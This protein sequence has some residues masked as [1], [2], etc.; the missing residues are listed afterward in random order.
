MNNN[1]SENMISTPESK[2][3]SS[4]DIIRF[5]SRLDAK[6]IPMHS[7]IIYSKD[8][9]VS[10]RYYIPSG[11]GKL[12]RM[13][14]ISKS[15][16]SLAVSLLIDEGKLSLSDKIISYFPEKIKGEVHP[17]LAEMT[18]EN[19]LMMRTCY[20][21]T[22]YNKF[23]M[24]SDWVG[25]FFTAI[26]THKPGTVFHYDTSSAHVLAALVEKITGKKLWD[27]F[28]EKLFPLNL[29]HES[30]FL[31]DG[32]GV[33]MGGSGLMATTE[34]LLKIGILL[35]NNGI[36]NGSQLISQEYILKATSCLSPNLVACPVPSEGS[37]YGYMFWCNERGGYSCYGMGGQ[38]IQIFPKQKL[39]LVTTADTQGYQGANQIILDSFYEEIFD[40]TDF[41]E[42]PDENP[43]ACEKLRICESSGHLP[44]LES[45]TSLLSAAS[46]T[47]SVC[48]MPVK[49]TGLIHDTCRRAYFTGINFK[50]D[51]A[52]GELELYR[53]DTKYSIYFAY[54]NILENTLPLYNMKCYSVCTR[55]DSNSLYIKLYVIDTSVGSVHIEIY[56]ENNGITM[57]MKKTEESLLSEFNGHYCFVF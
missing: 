32:Q 2:G 19:M 29:S 50:S 41:N 14:S 53:D 45:T 13:F 49:E 10:S 38:Y 3:L 12:H 23:D 25:S 24:S 6:K 37:G 56:F 35:L 55:P 27:Y 43:A 28:R 57:Y 40:K 1:F 54:N 18:I 48:D 7:V 17:Y 36:F 33:S 52:G 39:I 11:N 20:A 8:S 9:V 21:N 22:T 34:D 44:F 15:I 5:Y 47:V 42:K 51:S 30:Y 16:T 4:E 26:P 46:H 31:C